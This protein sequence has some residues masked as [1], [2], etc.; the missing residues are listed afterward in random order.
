MEPDGLRLVVLLVGCNPLTQPARV[1]CFGR[2]ERPAESPAP[3]GTV[4]A[5][6]GGMHPRTSTRKRS[7]R[8]RY[9]FTVLRH[10][11]QQLG[12]GGAL[13]AAKAGS[14]GFHP[15]PRVPGSIFEDAVGLDVDSRA[16]ELGSQACVLPFLAD[17]ERQ[18]VVG[19]QRP[20][21]LRGLV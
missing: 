4:D 8:I 19:H 11:S 21:R 13:S 12:C 17:R 15:T 16:R 3:D 1:E 14:Y 7:G 2:P 5:F 20:N 6:E 9:H 10:A 18:L